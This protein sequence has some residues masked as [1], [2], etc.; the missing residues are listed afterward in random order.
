MAWKRYN[1]IT[2]KPYIKCDSCYKIYEEKE[3]WNSKDSKKE[4]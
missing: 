3:E 4:K 2:K 1:I